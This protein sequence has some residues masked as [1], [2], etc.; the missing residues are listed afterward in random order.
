MIDAMNLI[1]DAIREYEENVEPIS[2]DH[3]DCYNTNITKWEFGG[4]LISSIK[5][6]MDD[7]VIIRF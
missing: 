6:R 4:P 3:I 2:V 7:N 1:A 5:T